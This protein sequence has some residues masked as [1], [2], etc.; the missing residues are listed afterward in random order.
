[1]R[2]NTVY[3]VM[4]G[5]LL[6]ACASAT[7][8]VPITVG[9]QAKACGLLTREKHYGPPNFGETP[10]KDSTFSA[11]VLRTTEPVRVIVPGHPAHA[12]STK[13]IQLYFNRQKDGRAWQ[14]KHL[15]VS[16]ESAEAITPSDIAPVNITI[17]S[18]KLK[19]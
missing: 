17:E 10:K 1:M 8:T 14:D 13:R 15:C 3:V 4:A 2:G 9:Q 7:P 11:W 19:Q 12:T 6:T 5:L 18:T 16:G